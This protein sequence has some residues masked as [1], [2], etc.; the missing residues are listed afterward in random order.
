V[1]LQHPLRGGEVRR[2][3]SDPILAFEVGKF[4]T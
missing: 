4:A 1:Q 3:Y 2:L